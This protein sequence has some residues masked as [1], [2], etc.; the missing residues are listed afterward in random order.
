M[1]KSEPI[2]DE[3]K[4]FMAG[5]LAAPQHYWPTYVADKSGIRDDEEI[6]MA[7]MR[8]GRKTAAEM[9]EIDLRRSVSGGCRWNPL[10]G[11]GAACRGSREALRLGD[12]ADQLQPR[13]CGSCSAS[14]RGR[15]QFIFRR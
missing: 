4:A 3:T 11:R 2:K 13:C 10:G 8:L 7:V 14:G 15:P 9:F 12:I 5:S 6:P 1:C